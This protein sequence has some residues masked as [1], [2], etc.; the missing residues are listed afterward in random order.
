M[1]FGLHVNIYSDSDYY[2][3]KLSSLKSLNMDDTPMIM[4]GLCSALDG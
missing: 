2:V 4:K 3:Q 1:V